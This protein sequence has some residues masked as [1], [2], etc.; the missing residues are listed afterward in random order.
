MGTRFSMKARFA[1][2]TGLPTP[3]TVPN[4]DQEE[5]TRAKR[6]KMT[7]EREREAGEKRMANYREGNN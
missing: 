4:P 2:D 5:S 3:P 7:R 6:R 1:V